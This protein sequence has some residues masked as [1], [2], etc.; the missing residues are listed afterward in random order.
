[1]YYYIGKKKKFNRHNN[2]KSK[3][4][5]ILCRYKIEKIW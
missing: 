4:I 2:A 1:M 5:V 3:Q